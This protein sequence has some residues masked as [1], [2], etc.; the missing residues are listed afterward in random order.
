MAKQSFSEG[1]AQGIPRSEETRQQKPPPAEAKLSGAQLAAAALAQLGNAKAGQGQ[2]VS[3]A[4]LGQ[5]TPKVGVVKAQQ[6][7]N[8]Q[9]SRRAVPKNTIVR[10]QTKRRVSAQEVGRNP[11]A[12][13]R[14]PRAG[15]LQGFKA[16]LTKAVAAS[17]QKFAQ[18]A[19]QRA[20][21][22]A[23][24]RSIGKGLGR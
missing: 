1:F 6:Q 11:T 2:T 18:A 4:K 23:P 3:R 19:G 17:G 5:L 8:G 7:S 24:S 16:A 20:R 14:A 10:D 15:K 13:K 9:R 21:A 12:A 22:A